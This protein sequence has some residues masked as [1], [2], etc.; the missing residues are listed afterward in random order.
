MKLQSWAKTLSLPLVGVVR[1]RFVFFTLA[2]YRGRRTWATPAALFPR[3]GE[4]Q[5]SLELDAGY[6]TAPP[7]VLELRDEIA[8][9]WSLPV[10]QRVEV[11]FRGG[12][13][14]AV[15]GTTNIAT[16]IWPLPPA[17]REPVLAAV[18]G[19]SFPKGPEAL[20]LTAAPTAAPHAP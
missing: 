10:G 13:R 7:V 18:S 1:L 16:R 4:Q 5:I 12:E 14:S 2:R 15:A 6:T 9:A 11:C 3:L 20:A 19:E 17:T 8:A